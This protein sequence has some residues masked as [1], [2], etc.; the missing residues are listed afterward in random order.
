MAQAL[1]RLIFSAD[2]PNLMLASKLAPHLQSL[3]V[4]YKIPTFSVKKILGK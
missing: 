1:P 3:F 2:V 4:F